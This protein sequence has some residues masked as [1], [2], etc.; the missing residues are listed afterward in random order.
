MKRPTQKRTTLA[1]AVLACLVFAAFAGALTFADAAPD[2]T[3]TLTVKAP[4]AME[5]PEGIEAAVY[6]VADWDS[7]AT[8][9]ATDEFA[10]L[11]DDLPRATQSEEIQNA[12]WQA[13]AEKAAALVA[14][15][16]AP[17]SV[18]TVAVGETLTLDEAGLYLLVFSEAQDSYNTYSCEPVLV[19]VGHGYLSRPE[20]EAGLEN[21]TVS[22]KVTSEPRDAAIEIVKTLGT[23]DA[24]AGT[25][26]F[27]FSVEAVLN[28][29]VVYSDVVTMFFSAPGTQTLRVEG[30]P[31]GSTVTVTEVY[32]GA[33]YTAQV[34]TQVVDRLSADEDMAVEFD[35]EYEPNRRGGGG[36]ENSFTFDEAG[37]VTWTHT[38]SASQA[39]TDG[40][41]E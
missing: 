20:T 3:C 2:E 30:I 41:Q 15:E 4:D 38:S 18:A 10:A 19:A 14:D 40:G 37:N 26:P 23:Y 39:E 36:V 16:A 1:F 17:H 27:V 35:N 21:V 34:D 6:L 12:Q 33:S 11:A 13:V 29:Q 5:V 25:A 8:F 24:T 7:T 9:R 31:A 32:S 28:E 22:L